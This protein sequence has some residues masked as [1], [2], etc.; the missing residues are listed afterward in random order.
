MNGSSVTIADLIGRQ[1]KRAGVTG[2]ETESRL[3]GDTVLQRVPELDLHLD[4]DG[5]VVIDLGSRQL[6]CRQHA[7]AILAEFSRPRQIAQ[8]LEVLERSVL[9]VEGW[10]HL[11][12]TIV[13]FHEA[14]VL[15]DESQPAP[16][17]QRPATGYGTA[18]VHIRMLDDRSRTASFLRAI[19][20]MVR[21]GDVVVDIGTGTGIL[22]VAAAQAGARHVYAIEQSGIGESATA[23]FAANGL[24]D[25]ITLVPGWSTEIDLPEQGD[26][27]V[28]EM[29]GNEPLGERI[30]PVTRDAVKRL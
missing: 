17:A 11:T 29:I 27:L 13:A 6:H 3:T 8:A 1:G 2:K 25:R 28:S 14:G 9:G 16:P 7:L 12:A 18:P 19:R 15:R 26:V 10:K 22:A 4:S 30:L 24:A 20:R 23:L 21:P 5:A